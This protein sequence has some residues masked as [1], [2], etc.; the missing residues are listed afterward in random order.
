MVVLP[1]VPDTSTNRRAEANLRR[2]I[3][4]QRHPATDDRTLTGPDTPRQPG[5]QKSYSYRCGCVCR[6]SHIGKS[7]D[8]GHGR[9]L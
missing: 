8:D 9:I 3:Q 4:G 7:G 5:R 1:L 6:T 2:R